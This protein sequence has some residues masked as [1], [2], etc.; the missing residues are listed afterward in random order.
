MA[1]TPPGLTESFE[2]E[3]FWWLPDGTD[4]EVPGVLRYEPDSGIQLRLL[5]SFQSLE[6]RI[7]FN[8]EHNPDAILG[9]L[10]E[11]SLPVTLLNN[12][13]IGITH[14][15]PGYPTTKYRSR[16]L[17]LGDHCTQDTPFLSIQSEFTGLES[18]LGIRS[19]ETTFIPEFD[20]RNRVT[21]VQA[22]ANYVSPEFHPIALEAI[23][24]DFGFNFSFS[25]EPENQ[26]RVEWVNRL[27]VSLAPHTPQSV[28][29]FLHFNVSVERLLAVL[30]GEPAY[31]TSFQLNQVEIPED[32]RRM[33]R[34]PA[35]VYYHSVY[36]PTDKSIAN[37]SMLI[38]APQ[39]GEQGVARLFNEW[40]SR[41]DVLE[42]LVNLYLSTTYKKTFPELTLITLVQALEGY[43]RSRFGGQYLSEA[44]YEPFY[45]RLVDAIPK[46]LP[47]D[48]RQS[49]RHGLKYRNEFALA[50][51]LKELVRCVP[52]ELQEWITGTSRNGFIQDIK[53]TRNHLA[54][55][56]S[57]LEDSA[58]SGA[59]LYWANARLG[60]WI[61]VL[62]FLELGIPENLIFDGIRRNQQYAYLHRERPD[63]R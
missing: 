40:F 35:H 37:Y 26:Q 43:H 6:Q 44:E 33:H 38:T 55:Q 59:A 30:F 20:E 46:E 52:V 57:E 9:W 18:W 10:I 8:Q 32:D 17:L 61:T 2:Y 51:R 62:I 31:C 56:T 47:S 24:A 5:G 14:R 41:S 16:Y 42:P 53:N 60:M 12:M 29:W 19:F 22:T 7:Q 1:F 28:E 11:P 48:M 27:A 36:T 25:A 49:L 58:L 34:T 3:G 15:F 4:N 45:R 23:N 13:G 50:R 21:R 54:H 63:G 39:L